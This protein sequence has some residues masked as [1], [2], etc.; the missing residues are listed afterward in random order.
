MTRGAAGREWQKEEG[1]E[2]EEEEWK[3]ADAYV[4]AFR[5]SRRFSIRVPLPYYSIYARVPR[6]LSLREPEMKMNFET[7]HENR[8]YLPPFFRL[9]LQEKTKKE[10][11]GPSL[12]VPSKPGEK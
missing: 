11:N 9:S 2:G 4:E 12:R 1:E 6:C 8:L 7:I 5:G 3:S 10:R